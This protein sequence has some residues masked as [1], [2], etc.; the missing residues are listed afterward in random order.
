MMTENTTPI[1][2]G[3][4]VEEDVPPP[5]RESNSVGIPIDPGEIYFQG[6]YATPDTS[7]DLDPD[8][9]RKIMQAAPGVT[10]DDVRKMEPD[11]IALFTDL[12]E[13]NDAIKDIAVDLQQS[14]AQGG[15]SSVVGFFRLYMNL[16]KIGAGELSAITKIPR[17]RMISIM[18][19]TVEMTPGEMTMIKEVLLPRYQKWRA[20]QNKPENRKRED[21]RIKKRMEKKRKKTRVY[22]RLTGAPILGLK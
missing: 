5:M 2:N 10:E 19:E 18:Q 15:P 7:N 9:I 16:T 6:Q 21:A 12:I 8:L 13:M 3:M 22:D 17:L 1:Q 11:E 14:A 4:I 20:L